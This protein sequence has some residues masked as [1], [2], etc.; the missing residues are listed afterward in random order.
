MTV[1]RKRPCRSATSKA[2]YAT[3]AAVATRLERD[4]GRPPTD[5]EIARLLATNVKFVTRA[6]VRLVRT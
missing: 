1:Q 5:E 4:L 3:I 2:R 6:R